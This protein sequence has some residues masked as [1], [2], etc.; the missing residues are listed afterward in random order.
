MTTSDV[1]SNA[2]IGLVSGFVATALWVGWTRILRGLLIPWYISQRYQ[3]V[4]IQGDWFGKYTDSD[5]SHLCTVRIEQTGTQI[6]GEITEL[7]GPDKGK[8]YAIKGE[9]RDL[10]LTLFYAESNFSRIDRGVIALS[11]RENGCILEGH[12]VFYSD[13]VHGLK[14]RPYRWKKE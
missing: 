2:A 4:L 5:E 7:E 14:T 10:I 1:F 6:T 13:S 8:R 9:M 12:T 3:G 11:L